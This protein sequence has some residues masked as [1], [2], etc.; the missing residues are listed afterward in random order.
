[1]RIFLSAGEPSGDLHGSNLIQEL[2]H[3]HPE[4]ECVGFGG[5]RMSAAGC[6]LL[7]PLCR[8]AVMGFVRLLTALPRFVGIVNLADRYFREQRPDAVVLIDYPGLHWW[9]ARRAHAQGIPVFYFI[10]PQMWGWAGWRVKKMRRYIDHTLC[11]LPFEHAWYA[12]RGVNAHYVGHPYF[13]ELAQQ[14]L[15]ESFVA[16]ERRRGGPIIG[17]LPGSRHQEIRM[18]FPT[19]LRA[20]YLIH[21]RRPD[22]RFLIANLEEKQRQLVQ[23]QLRRYPELPISAHVGRTP[24]II[25]LAHA[26]IS[27]SGSVSLE[28]L[29]RC[30]PTC[31]VY[32]LNPLYVQLAKW[33][34]TCDYITLVNLLAGKELFPEYLSSR[35]E[36][37]AIAGHVLRW[38]NDPPRY[39]RLTH[40]LEALRQQVAQP[41]ACERAARYIL[42]ALRGKNRQAA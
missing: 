27:V 13:D 38:L 34:V 6:Q 19:Q 42:R 31:I 4:I 33:L 2:R 29:N 18:N 26:C 25:E 12:E 1:M 9:L 35:C 14:Q 16:A 3:Q 41:G 40:D 32:R 15:D 24:E 17:I 39:C 10:P 20:A 11:T 21:Q 8:H 37:E 23:N 28:L 30:K 5:D 7:Y 22:V 36:A